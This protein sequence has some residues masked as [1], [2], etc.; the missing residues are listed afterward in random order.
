MYENMS[1]R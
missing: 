1:L